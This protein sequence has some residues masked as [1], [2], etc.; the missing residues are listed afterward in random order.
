MD[1]HL[2]KSQIEELLA[3][4]TVEAFGDTSHRVHV[5]MMEIHPSSDWAGLAAYDNS[6]HNG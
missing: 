6:K 3:G 2:T 5:S 4:K 1:V